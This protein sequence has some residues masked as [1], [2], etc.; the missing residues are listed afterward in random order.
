MFLLISSW[1]KEGKHDYP[2]KTCCP[3]TTLSLQYTNCSGSAC[4]RFEWRVMSKTFVKLPSELY[5]PLFG[6]SEQGKQLPMIFSLSPESN[7]GFRGLWHRSLIKSW[8]VKFQLPYLMIGSET[9]EIKSG[10]KI[11][12]LILMLL[13]LIHN[14]VDWFW[15]GWKN[16]GPHR[17]SM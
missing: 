9:M 10:I 12:K 13:P 8:N 14:K 3:L 4:V 7:W 5:S 2:R 16:P 11:L 1:V 6:L 15:W 17:I